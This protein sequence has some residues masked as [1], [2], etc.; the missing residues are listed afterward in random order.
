VTV[1]TAAVTAL[2]VDAVATPP[3]TGANL[4]P[5]NGALYV[6]L[7][8]GL[9]IAAISLPAGRR[10]VGLTI[11]IVGWFVALGIAEGVTAVY[12]PDPPTSNAI[13]AATY[14]GS[15][16]WGTEVA[17]AL[18]AL[19]ALAAVVVPVLAR[20]RFAAEPAAP[21]PPDGRPHPS[22]RGAV[23]VAVGL[24]LIA[25]SLLP[26]VR[27][28]A[29]DTLSKFP[30]SWDAANRITWSWLLQRGAMPMRDFFFPYG[31]EW[32]FQVF[33]LGPVWQWLNDVAILG[34]SAWTLWRLGNRSVVRV[35]LG[36]LAL[37]L[38]ATWGDGEWRY[39]PALLVPLSYAALGPGRSTRLT[40]RHAVFLAACLVAAFNGADL[41]YAY[42]LGGLACV[43][44]AEWL[45]RGG[46]PV[47]W[48]RPLAIDAI[49]VV[50][51][52]VLLFLSWIATGTVK[53]NL[54]WFGG[55]ADVSIQSASDQQLYGALAAFS[56]V[57]GFRSAAIAVP[58]LLL[59]LGLLHIRWNGRA[60]R[61]VGMLLVAGGGVLTVMLLKFTVRPVEQLTPLALLVFTWAAILAWQRRAWFVAAAAGVVAGALLVL[62]QQADSLGIIWH[63]LREA[64]TTVASDARIVSDRGQIQT[65][66]EHRFTPERFSA[67][68]EA[69]LVS[70]YYAATGSA[71]DARFAI[72][73]DYPILYV[74][75]HQAPPYQLELYNSSRMDEQKEV[76][77]RLR[78]ENPPF[79]IWR[80]D[81]AVDG[82]P[83]SVR[84]PLL[85]TWAVRR[86]T[87][88][89][90]T[91][92][93][94][95]LRKRR[96]GEPVPYQFW[97]THFAPYDLGYV[98]ADA[99][100]S[101][102]PTCTSGPGCVPYAIV[103]GHP[104]RSGEPIALKAVGH[105]GDYHVA[106]RSREGADTYAIRLDRL[107]FSPIIGPTPRLASTTPGY[108]LTI[109]RLR[110]GDALY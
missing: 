11:A 58:P 16:Y 36:L 85:F 41:L 109:K 110:A 88:A 108:T 62:V 49:P 66:G 71:K 5:I 72:L 18:T 30:A 23:V 86:Y 1:V 47:R 8:A 68:P 90:D 67:Y 45:A 77:A 38:L 96:P 17:A 7:V 15:A 56:V 55:L 78:R 92:N 82:V 104:A 63:G 42:G 12:N 81:F 59:V 48:L 75:L 19:I 33:P 4:T 26:D 31:Y 44:V 6:A 91:Q 51:A 100:E 73:G 98:P 25:L 9:A 74:L 103:R 43:L 20:R 22:R 50:V 21:D 97:K 35:L 76:L 61:G 54:R 83:Y 46:S 10:L 40:W 79:L 65:A 69:S 24:G 13:G 102:L 27:G 29:F 37:A 52:F 93:A 53:G 99:A 106:F 87:P 64:P 94:T 39:A 34:L 14:F 57:P 84:T 101:D 28:A 60:S 3:T 32:T 107:W 89:R 70:D 80:R 105:G 95:I 2:I